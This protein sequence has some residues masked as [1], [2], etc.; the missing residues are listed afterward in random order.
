MSL[1]LLTLMVYRFVDVVAFAL[2]L[3]VAAFCYCFAYW[4]EVAIVAVIDVWYC[5]CY[6]SCFNSIGVL[7]LLSG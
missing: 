6:L 1:L 7:L 5:R 2:A 3:H 4:V